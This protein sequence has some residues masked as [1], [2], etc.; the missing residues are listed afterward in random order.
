MKLSQNIHLHAKVNINRYI[1]EGQPASNSKS[2]H[3]FLH[4]WVPLASNLR[5]EG[6]SEA[7]SAVFP[8]NLKLFADWKLAAYDRLW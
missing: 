3:H 2:G 5:E 6:E 8:K 4:N 1:H 7:I